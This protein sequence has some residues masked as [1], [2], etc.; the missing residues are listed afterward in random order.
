[1]KNSMDEDGK[2]YLKHPMDDAS[3]NEFYNDLSCL[4]KMDRVEKIMLVIIA[5]LILGGGLL[6]VLKGR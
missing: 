3:V 5:V 6:I 4:H 1:M 2:Y